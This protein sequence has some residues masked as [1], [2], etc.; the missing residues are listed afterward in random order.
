MNVE[1]II[2]TYKIVLWKYYIMI[3][4]LNNDHMD[5]ISEVCNDVNNLS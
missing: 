3:K 5:D 1:N 4:C 2:Y